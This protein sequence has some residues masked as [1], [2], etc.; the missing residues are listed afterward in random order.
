MLS[1]ATYNVMFHSLFS[2]ADCSSEC[3]FFSSTKKMYFNF[4]NMRHSIAQLLLCKFPAAKPRSE[5]G[6]RM[7][8]LDDW[9]N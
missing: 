7:E 2:K 6:I 8:M 9:S 5:Y 1:G 3:T 4:T